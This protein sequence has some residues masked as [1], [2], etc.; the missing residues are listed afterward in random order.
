ML[1]ILLNNP[2]KVRPEFFQYPQLPCTI[3]KEIINFAES[4]PE[5]DLT[6]DP[7]ITSEIDL[8]ALIELV[9]YSSKFMVYAAQS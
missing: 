4:R 7:S 6:E 9:I 3:F 5:F 8:K 1:T 2:L